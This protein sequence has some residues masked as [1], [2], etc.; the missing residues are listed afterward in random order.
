L[1]GLNVTNWMIFLN[2][3]T[4][5][6]D[7]T[8]RC[9]KHRITVDKLNESS[10]PR[11]QWVFYMSRTLWVFKLHDL[12]RMIWRR[13][14]WVILLIF[15][16]SMSLLNQEPNESSRS[17]KLYLSLICHKFNLSC[18]CHELNASSKFHEL[19]KSFPRTHLYDWPRLSW[20]HRSFGRW[21]RTSR[22][23]RCLTCF[24]CIHIYVYIHEYIH[25]YI[26]IYIYIYIYSRSKRCLTYFVCIC[27]YVYTHDYIHVYIYR[28][29]NV[30]IDMNTYTL[31]MYLCI[32][33]HSYLDI[34]IN[35]N[36]DIEICMYEYIY[37]DAY[38]HM[39]VC[40]FAA[41]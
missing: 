9:H 14:Q 2:L 11:T 19:T 29:R 5:L 17:H 35:I 25:I 12:I 30:C 26:H 36:I 28:Y 3:R 10:K 34:H 33:K 13:K 6:H 38:I 24:V 18:K 21:Q 20:Q 4:H 1:K 32:F 37:I 41:W 39:H 23:R 40:E 8:R 27:I 31:C 15:T 7:E 22:S 16:N